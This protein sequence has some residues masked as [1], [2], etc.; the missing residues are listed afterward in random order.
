M[1]CLKVFFITCLWSAGVKFWPSASDCCAKC[2]NCPRFFYSFDFFDSFG[3]TGSTSQ[4]NPS[5]TSNLIAAPNA[6][7]APDFFDSFGPT[8]CT[9]QLNPSPTSNLTIAGVGSHAQSQNRFQEQKHTNY[10]GQTLHCAIRQPFEQRS[11][12]QQGPSQV[13]QGQTRGSNQQDAYQTQNFPQAT[14][15]AQYQST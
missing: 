6:P 13:S 4:S 15:H 11:T 12:Q 8:G 10:Q 3:S 7:A 14:Q 1:D 9:S 5:M 2:T